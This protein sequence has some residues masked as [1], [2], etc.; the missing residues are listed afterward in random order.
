MSSSSEYRR[1]QIFG[2]TMA[3]I[4]LLLLFC[5]LL[6]LT[7][8]ILNEKK[9][10]DDY[11]FDR[12][13]LERV[14][15][16]LDKDK[17]SLY[18]VLR[19]FKEQIKKEEAALKDDSVKYNDLR[20]L[21]ITLGSEYSKSSSDSDK[22]KI[23]KEKILKAGVMEE[24]GIPSSVNP[25]DL[26]SAYKLIESLKSSSDSAEK[27]L[28]DIQKNLASTSNQLDQS[29]NQN[30]FLQKELEKYAGKGLGLPPCWVDKSGNPNYLYHVSIFDDSLKV[31][32]I[33][34]SDD[35]TKIQH[36]D[37]INSVSF[38]SDLKISPAEF[39]NLF[40]PIKLAANKGAGACEYWVK[41]CDKVSENSK[42]LYKQRMGEVWRVFHPRS[43]CE[44]I[45]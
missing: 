5:L 36:A 13:K 23:I 40:N 42:S 7:H 11:E 31:S 19:E 38:K 26:A 35:L 34:T 17:N 4:M 33:Y 10:I 25:D 2:F 6:I 14:L 16:S 28:L 8:K 37:L 41:V 15:Q 18:V 43:S 27:K 32:K 9:K 45:S 44:N 22:I 12:S 30:K 1:G 39:Y 21:F 24:G 3:E 20:K 29:L